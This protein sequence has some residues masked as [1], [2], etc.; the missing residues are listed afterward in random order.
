MFASAALLSFD[1]CARGE[2][3]FA[4]FD[5]SHDSSSRHVFFSVLSVRVFN[6]VK[7]LLTARVEEYA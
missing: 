7:A 2:R 4:L 5:L 3:S 1:K 6:A